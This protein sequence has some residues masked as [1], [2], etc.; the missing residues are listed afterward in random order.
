[1]RLTTPVPV[2]RSDA[3]P[4]GIQTVAGSIPRSFVEIV[5]KIFSTAILYLPLISI[6]LPRKSV[7]RLTYSLDMTIVVD[8]DVK[9]QNTLIVPCISTK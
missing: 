1:M 7:V 8:F 2:A 6:S 9:L 5:H 3:H 4:P